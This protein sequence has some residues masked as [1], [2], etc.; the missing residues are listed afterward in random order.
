MMGFELPFPP[1]VNH[2]WMRGK[3]NR[4]YSCAKVK[5][6]HKLATSLIVE[7]K[8]LS[9]IE[10]PIKGRLSVT[11]TLNEKDKRRR[12]MD[13][14]NKSALDACTKNGL[15]EDDCQIDELVIRRGVINKESPNIFIHIEEITN[16]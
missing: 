4:L 6:F 8:S 16:G 13:N 9:S 14:Y 11:I 5:D 2:T 10:F 7:A 3:G 1:S 12:D 15:W